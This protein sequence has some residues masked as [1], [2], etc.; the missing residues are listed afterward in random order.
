MLLVFLESGAIAVFVKTPGLS[1]IKTRL[2][3]TIGQE[4]AEKFHLFSSSCVE[5]VITETVKTYQKITP[6][7]AIAE[8][9]GLSYS[10]WS[11][12]QR[13]YQGEGS[14]GERLSAIYDELLKK[15]S[16]V[17]FLGADSP[18]ISLDIL[19]SAI[20][21][22]SKFPF[23]IGRAKDGGFYLFGGRVAIPKQT[24]LSVQYSCD[25]TATTLIKYL[26]PLGSIAEVPTL[27]DVDTYEDLKEISYAV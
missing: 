19:T 18:Q 13:I 4:A 20:D 3:Q 21:S 14:L 11:R 1:P 27:T 23:V 2:A 25:Q 17:I 8:K 24:W 12:F 5:A 9:I 7:W 26:L 6:Y 22:M 15:H 10:A 16:F